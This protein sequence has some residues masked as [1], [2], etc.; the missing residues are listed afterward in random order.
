MSFHPIN[1]IEANATSGI[2]VLE[3]MLADNR[4]TSAQRADLELARTCFRAIQKHARDERAQKRLEPSDPRSLLRPT[5]LGLQEEHQLG[6][7]TPGSNR[8][9]RLCKLVAEASDD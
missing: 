1:L 2:G 3:R 6:R 7:H 8:Y 5:Q 4:T 9:C